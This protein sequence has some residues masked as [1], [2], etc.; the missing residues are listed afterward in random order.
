MEESFGR[1][2]QSTEKPEKF[3]NCISHS[4]VPLLQRISGK[5]PNQVGKKWTFPTDSQLRG[6]FFERSK[7]SSDN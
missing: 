2:R 6:N 3:P 7:T 4:G 1:V 5:S